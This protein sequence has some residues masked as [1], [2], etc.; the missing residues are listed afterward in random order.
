MEWLPIMIGGFALGAS[1]MV[2]DESGAQDAIYVVSSVDQ[3]RYLVRN[4]PDRVEAADK[5][6]RIRAKLV[7]VVESMRERFG[8]DARTRQMVR[9][10]NPDVLVEA[11]RT[12]KYTSYSVNKG[13]KVV[14][15][16]RSRDDQEALV[17][18]N[19]LTFV[20]LHELAHICTPSVGHN[21]EFW[22]NF[23]WILQHAVSIQV[24]TPVD[25]SKQPQEYCGMQVTDSPLN[26][27]S[28]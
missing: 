8:S 13:E 17:E 11:A 5:M 26:N 28:L 19:M 22:R 6:A 10:F 20:A 1:Y 23:K 14:M 15:C 25:Y 4:M 12:S 18:D 21:Q 27:P 9:N 7:R 24:Y 2:N 16:L 3:R